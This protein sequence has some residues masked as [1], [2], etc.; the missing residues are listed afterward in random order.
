M[1][2]PSLA[3]GRMSMIEA[4]TTYEFQAFVVHDEALE[5][6]FTPIT[7]TEPNQAKALEMLL[8]SRFLYE[9]AHPGVSL[10]GRPL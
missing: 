6:L 7:I 1:L 9:I 4:P 8:G 3:R 10:P 5:R 2:K